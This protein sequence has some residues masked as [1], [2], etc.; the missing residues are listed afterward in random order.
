MDIDQ[1]PLSEAT[2][3]ILLT[4]ADKP[5]HGYSILQEVD[6]LSGGRVS[7]STGTLYGAI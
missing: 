1:A 2:F 5:R 4:L 7:L 6:S 3:L